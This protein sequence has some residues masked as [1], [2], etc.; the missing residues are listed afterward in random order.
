MDRVAAVVWGEGGG[1]VALTWNAE[2][3]ES[4]NIG[5]GKQEAPQSIM[6]ARPVAR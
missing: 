2:K 4:T 3:P 5:S 6:S 1:G